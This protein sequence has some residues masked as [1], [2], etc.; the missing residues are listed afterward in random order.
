MLCGWTVLARPKSNGREK[1]FRK[2]KMLLSSM[3]DLGAHTDEMN[4]NER[5]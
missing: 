1:S 4:K 2:E 3:F 5:K